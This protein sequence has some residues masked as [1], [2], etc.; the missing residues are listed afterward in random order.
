[1]LNTSSCIETHEVLGGLR[2]KAFLDILDA[3]SEHRTHLVANVGSVEFD[4]LHTGEN[5]RF[6]G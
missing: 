1:M 6:E 5:G 3:A 2:G 4:G